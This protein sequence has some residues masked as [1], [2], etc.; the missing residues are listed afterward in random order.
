MIQYIL[1]SS[2]EYLNY[3]QTAINNCKQ[4]IMDKTKKEEIEKEKFL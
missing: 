3:S 2:W 4:D 1:V